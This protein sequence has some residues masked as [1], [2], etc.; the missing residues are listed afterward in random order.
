[1]NKITTITEISKTDDEL[2]TKINLFGCKLAN[3]RKELKL[4]QQDI[5]L[6][7]GTTQNIQSKFERGLT[8]PRVE[9]LYKLENL[10][11]DIQNL[12]FSKTN[13][14]VYILN[15]FEKSLM[16][17]FRNADYE[18]QLQAIGLLATGNTNQT[19][20][21]QKGGDFNQ[22]NS[23]IITEKQVNKNIQSKKQ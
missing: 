23:V 6:S 20:M 22:N 18:T 15:K 8:S 19:V 12:I 21:N 16:D 9:Y 7:V 4:S 10:G 5:A 3:Q 14:D 1:M 11:F 17:F 13:E 2:Q